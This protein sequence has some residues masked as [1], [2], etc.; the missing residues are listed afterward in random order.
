MDIDHLTAKATIV[1]RRSPE[2]V[3]SALIDAEQ[4]SK[5]W[6]ARKDAG[7][8]EGEDCTW[9]VGSGDEAPS[10]EVHV[11]EVD[12]PNRLVFEWDN[13]GE[14]TQV[15]WQVEEAGEGSSILSVEESGFTG[16]EESILTR[17]IDSTKGFN[18]EV[19]AAKAVIELGGELNVVADHA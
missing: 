9:Y 1:V 14:M 11:K 16:T 7:L 19:V 12:F 17:V 13:G 2:E 6:F 4:M 5:F 15:V 8:K 18:Q 3:L 10:F